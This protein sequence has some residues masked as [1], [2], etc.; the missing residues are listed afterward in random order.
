[1]T[2]TTELWIFEKCIQ[3]ND[4]FGPENAIFQD[5]KCRVLK[6]TRLYSLSVMIKLTQI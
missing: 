2:L 6:G 4:M 5:K 1:M 3:C